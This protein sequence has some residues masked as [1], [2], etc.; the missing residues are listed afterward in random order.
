MPLVL[1]DILASCG[2]GGV[3]N[4]IIIIKKKKKRTRDIPK[5]RRRRHQLARA[6]ELSPKELIPGVGLSIRASSTIAAASCLLL[7]T[8]ARDC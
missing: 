2:G 4:K 8:K 1:P 5:Y 7:F 6:K 3:S